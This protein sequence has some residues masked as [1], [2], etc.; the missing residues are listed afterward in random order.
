MLKVSVQKRPKE[1]APQ[2]VDMSWYQTE[3]A[4]IDHQRLVDK[5]NQPDGCN[6]YQRYL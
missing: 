5:I 6:G 1:D 3:K 4:K 2:S